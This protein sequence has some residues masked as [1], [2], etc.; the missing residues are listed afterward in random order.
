[1]PPW[2]KYQGQQ[3][4]GPW[5]RYQN[6][7]TENGELAYEYDDPQA[8]QP[9]RIAIDANPAPYNPLERLGQSAQSTLTGALQGA[10]LGA[11]DELAAALGTPIKGVANLLGGQDSIS[12]WEDVGPFLGRS[13]NSALQGQRGLNEQAYEQAPAA[14]IAGDLAGSVGFGGGLASKGV[15]MFGTV[16]RPT[17]AGMAARGATEGGLTGFGSAYN[18]SDSDQA[19]DRLSSGVAG[20]L[21][22][23]VLGGATGGVLGGM[24]GKAQANA[25]PS[26]QALKGAG[27]DLYDS[28]RASGVLMPASEFDNVASKIESIATARNVKLPNGKINSTYAA[29]SGPLDVFDAFKGRDM[30]LDDMLAV[31]TNVRDAAASPEPAVSKIAM[32]MF[33]E[34]NDSLYRTFPDIKEADDLYWRGKTGELIDRL[35]QLAT[36]R[37]GQYSQSG[38]ENAL[39]AEFRLLE[40]QII[41]GRVK[42]I[43]ADL[44]EQISKVAQGD[45]LQDFSRWLSKFGAQNPVTSIPAIAAGIGTGSIIPSLGIWGTAKGAG[46]VARALAFEKFRGAGASARSG[47]NIPAWEFGP[48]AGAIVRSTGAV[49]GPAVPNAIAEALYGNPKNER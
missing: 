34:L 22:G 31:R 24:A 32:E 11:Y 29:L 43:P 10:T 45:D 48:G 49:A 9:L 17:I 16:A 46:E 26:S 20:A 13:F 23:A 47:G 18:T 35:G 7:V 14:F 33:D 15:G 44:K 41:K 39:R 5:R 38:M 36:S 19:I 2:E 4:T 6:Q 40:R 42:G 1:M 27:S 28:V 3:Q 8:G 21:T 37:S 25:V 12:G 30:S